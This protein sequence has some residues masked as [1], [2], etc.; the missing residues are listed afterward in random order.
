[1]NSIDQPT[2][3]SAQ[4]AQG[5]WFRYSAY[6]VSA[7][8]LACFAASF[9][10]L[11]KQLFSGWNGAYLVVLAFLVA[12]DRFLSNRILEMYKFPEKEWFIYR[13]SEWIVI[14]LSVKFAF[15]LTHSFSFLKTDW[16][17]LYGRAWGGF[18]SPEFFF[19]MIILFIIWTVSGSLA[20]ILKKLEVDERILTIEQESG[21]YEERTILRENLVS[22]VLTIGLVMVLITALSGME[23]SEN[24]RESTALQGSVTILLI[25]FFL[26]L[27]LLSL[28][29]LN[30]LSTNWIRDGIPVR[31]SLVKNWILSSVAVIFILAVISRLLPSAYTI[32]ILELLNYVF[33]LGVALVGYLFMLLAVPFFLVLSLISALF[34]FPMDEALPEVAP[35]F[36]PPPAPVESTPLAWVELLKSIFFWVS[37]VGL[38]IF[39]LYTYWH[40][41][42]S[43]FSGIKQY[44]IFTHLLRFWRWMG[45]FFRQANRQLTQKVKEGWQGLRVRWQ[46]TLEHSPVQNLNIRQLSPKDKVIFYYLT[47][48]KR[49]AEKGLVRQAWQT[50]N[51]YLLALKSFTKDHIEIEKTGMQTE[52]RP[53][54]Q[55][56]QPQGRAESDWQTW[57]EDV[58]SLTDNF[59]QARYSTKTINQSQATLTKKIW[60]RLGKFFDKLF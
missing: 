22:L 29:Q 57:F 38:V 27:L 1:M 30:L 20:E 59:M 13:L 51:E 21:I 5:L 47:L 31:S 49:A 2:E 11:G 56:E 44:P 48:V 6:L 46:D 17:Y 35:V 9:L 45:S 52:E 7:G 37:I 10:A 19:V 50:P 23:F 14:I 18:F 24:W 54:M 41:N 4:P 42:K 25:Y 16:E 8:L 36:T 55:A 15:Y 28:T 32:G 33:Q 40:E 53:G 12:I 3:N 43:I 39:A 58:Q 26:T 34:N 60:E